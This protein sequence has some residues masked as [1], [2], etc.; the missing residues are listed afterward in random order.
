MRVLMVVATT[1]TL[2]LVASTALIYTIG[3]VPFTHALGTGVYLSMWLGLGFGAIFSSAV[4]PFAGAES[5]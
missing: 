3:D 5:H 1:V 4:I 2:V